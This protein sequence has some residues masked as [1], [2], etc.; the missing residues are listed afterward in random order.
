MWA[1]CWKHG[2]EALSCVKKCTAAGEADCSVLKKDSAPLRHIVM[3]G[4]INILLKYKTSTVTARTS[5]NCGSPVVDRRNIK[6]GL[7]VDA[8]EEEQ[9]F[10]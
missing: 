9:I 5:Q 1:G 7:L 3:M 10:E 2:N 6:T 4:T 8:I